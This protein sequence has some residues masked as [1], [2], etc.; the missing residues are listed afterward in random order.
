MLKNGF[1]TLWQKMIEKDNLN[2]V[3]GVD[4]KTVYRHRR[5]SW[6]CTDDER[7][8]HFY[9]FVVWTPELKTSLHKFQPAHEDEIDAFSRTT[10]HYYSTSLI[11]SLN[12]KRGTT[13][14]DYMFDNVL[15]KR[16]HSLWAQRDSYAALRN[17]NGTDYQ[18]GNL[19]S[20]S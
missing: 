19:P 6:L 20:G 9:K 17:Y 4:I 15:K 16:E 3:Y 14:I 7:E 5:G 2:V 1:Q 8:C 10:V 11:D 18:N 13:A 12:V